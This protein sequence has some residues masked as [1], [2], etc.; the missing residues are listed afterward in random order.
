M[1]LNTIRQNRVKN[2]SMYENRQDYAYDTIKKLVLNAELSPNSRV[3]RAELSEKL[4]IGN[5]PM[6]EAI[7]RLEKEG[8]FRIMPQSG[9]YVSKINIEQV[10]QAYFVRQNIE[11]RIFE[12]PADMI[13]GKQIKELE[14][15]LVIQRLLSDTNDNEMFFTFD[16]EFHEFFYK[17]VNKEHV[18]RWMETI[19]LSL[20]RYQHLNLQ[21]EDASWHSIQTD[22][23]VIVKSIKKKSKELFKETV[24][25][26][27]NK[28]KPELNVVVKQ[29]PDFFE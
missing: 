17:V 4:H 10:K 20:R 15:M 12:E 25:S 29:F 26:H 27:L 18:W 5:T 8:L 7:I 6:R 1:R 21:I 9:T 2:M 14:R 11:K 28:M 16:E 24:E 13:T 3:S 22:H 19:S 23:E